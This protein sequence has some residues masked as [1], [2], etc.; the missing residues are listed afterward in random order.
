M[1]TATNFSRDILDIDAEKEVE[2]ITAR[3][4]TILKDKLKRKGLVVALSGGI[5]SSVTTALAIRALGPERVQVLLMPERHSAEETADLSRQVAETFG[6]PYIYENISEIL[7][8]VG[9]YRRYDEAVRQ[10]VPEYG[11]GWKSKLVIP[12]VIETKRL[13]IFTI[14]RKRFFNCAY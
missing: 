7:S 13:N 5:D 11:E 12:N 1:A 10:A 14:V 9:F 6:A 4:K 2:K 3:I 8:A